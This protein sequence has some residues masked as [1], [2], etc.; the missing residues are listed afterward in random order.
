MPKLEAVDHDQRGGGG[1]YFGF[2]YFSDDTRVTYATGH[3]VTHGTGGWA[4]ITEAH[5]TLAQKYLDKALP[6]WNADKS[7]A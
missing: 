6:G 3:G 2:V 4:E 7:N 5:R 1:V